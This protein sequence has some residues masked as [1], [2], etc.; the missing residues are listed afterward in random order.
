MEIGFTLALLAGRTN[1]FFFV[2]FL[3]SFIL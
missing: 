1:A 3:I 2:R